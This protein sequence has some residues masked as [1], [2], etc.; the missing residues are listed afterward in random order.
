MS[1][2]YQSVTVYQEKDK[3]IVETDT[4]TLKFVGCSMEEIAAFVR[5][6]IEE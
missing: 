5:K 4:N 6:L 1:V 3:I 2:E